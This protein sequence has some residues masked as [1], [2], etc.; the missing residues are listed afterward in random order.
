[1]LSKYAPDTVLNFKDKEFIYEA[2]KAQFDEQGR[3][4]PDGDGVS[5]ISSATLD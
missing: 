4:I 2:F 3:A 5:D 1:M